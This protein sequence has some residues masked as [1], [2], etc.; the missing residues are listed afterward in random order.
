MLRDL[1]CG[2]IFQNL[3]RAT[4]A[5]WNTIRPSNGT[6][7]NVNCPAQ[8]AGRVPKDWQAAIDAV[9]CSFL[10]KDPSP[11]ETETDLRDR[12]LAFCGHLNATHRIYDRVLLVTHMSVAN[13]VCMRT[14]DHDF[15]QGST[16]EAWAPSG[17]AFG[18]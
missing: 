17:P 13:V 7:S 2:Q 4:L 12:V 9:H 11:D 3:F 15:P 14:I 16:K 5:P 6:T 1:A 10:P 18:S 8:E